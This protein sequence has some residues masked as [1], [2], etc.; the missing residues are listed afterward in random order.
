MTCEKVCPNWLYGEGCN[1]ICSCI[2][3]NSISCDVMTGSCNCKAGFKGSDCNEVCDSGSY[4]MNCGS[5]CNCHPEHSNDRAKCDAVNGKC[6]CK[7]GWKGRDCTERCPSGYF[8]RECS[9]ACPCNLKHMSGDCHDEN[10]TCFCK[11]GYQGYFCNET[12]SSGTFGKDCLSIC[13][14]TA[15]DHVTGACQ[16]QS[17]GKKVEPAVIAVPIVVVLL[18]LIVAAVGFV[19]WR[20]KHTHPA[21]KKQKPIDQSVSMRGLIDAAAKEPIPNDVAD[22]SSAYQHVEPSPNPL[23]DVANVQKTDTTMNPVYDVANVQKTDSAMNPVYF[24]RLGLN[25]GAADDSC[26]DTLERG[27]VANNAPTHTVNRHNASTKY[28][29][30]END[31]GSEYS[32]LGDG[33]LKAEEAYDHLGIQIKEFKAPQDDQYAHLNMNECGNVDENVHLNSIY[34]SRPRSTDRDS[35]EATYGNIDNTATHANDIIAPYANY[36]PTQAVVDEAS[37]DTPF[38][39]DPSRLY[40]KVDKSQKSRR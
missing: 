38:S 6:A 27:P 2:Q 8:G 23:Y 36:D 7:R 20:R 37:D 16:G 22:Q 1:L 31:A 33:T 9:F 17:A 10:G 29:N 14:C 28:A 12:C 21:L 3:N 39:L 40:G 19:F 30:L 4:G 34:E 35:D 25:G 26:Y 5:R 13:K 32:H 15:C 11:N 24:N 18:L